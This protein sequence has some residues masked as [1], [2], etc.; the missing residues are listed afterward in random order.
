MCIL[1]AQRGRKKALDPLG[2]ELQ[3]VVNHYMGAR[4]RSSLGSLE[5]HPVLCICLVRLLSSPTY[6]L[7]LLGGGGERWGRWLCSSQ[8]LIDQP[9]LEFAMIL[10]VL[11]LYV[12]ALQPHLV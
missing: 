7:L 1:G 12:C 6:S 5:E 8:G 4:N 9:C 11:G 2:Q 3:M 10:R